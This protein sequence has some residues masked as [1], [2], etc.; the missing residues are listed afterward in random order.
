[1]GGGEAGSLDDL[2]EKR[3]R[4]L[5]LMLRQHGGKAIVSHCYLNVCSALYIVKE[6]MHAE[7]HFEPVC[8]LLLCIMWPVELKRLRS[9]VQGRRRAECESAEEPLNK[10]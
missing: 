3:E 9:L 5:P 8:S 7:N 10:Y 1:M 2:L 6:N 4:K